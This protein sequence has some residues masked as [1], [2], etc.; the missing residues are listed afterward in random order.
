MEVQPKTRNGE[1]EGNAEEGYLEHKNSRKMGH[2]GPL[3][4][5]LSL[6]GSNQEGNRLEEVERGPRIEMQVLGNPFPWK[7]RGK[8]FSDQV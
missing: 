8:E 4:T 5:N 7:M 2:S 3:S 6:F 1:F